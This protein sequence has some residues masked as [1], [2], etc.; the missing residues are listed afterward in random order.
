MKNTTF[1]N[2][3]IK[4]IIYSFSI[5]ILINGIISISCENSKKEFTKE[6]WNKKEDV[7]Y[8]HRKY[9]VDDLIENHLKIGMSYDKVIRVLGQPE[10]YSQNEDYRLVYEV[11]IDH[12]WNIDPVKVINLNLDFNTDSLLQNIEIQRREN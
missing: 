7:Y 12:A 11:E 2:I 3:K 10:V 1:E 9:I 5:F 6:L 8:E 4:T